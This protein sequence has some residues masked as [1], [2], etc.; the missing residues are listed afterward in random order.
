MITG[1]KENYGMLDSQTKEDDP[2]PFSIHDYLLYMCQD[3]VWADSICIQLLASMWRCRVTVLRSDSCKEI[4][5]RHDKDL[6]GADFFLVFNCDMEVGHYNAA[7]RVDKIYIAAAKLVRIR[8]FNFDK[9]ME[10][11]EERGEGVEIGKDHVVAER[12]KLR[13]L[14]YK[15]QK[16]DQIQQFIEDTSGVGLT[17]TDVS[18]VGKMPSKTSVQH[19][20]K[21]KEEELN[22]Q[23]VKEGDVKCEKCHRDF[24]STAD[25][26]Q[27]I[28]VKHNDLYSYVCS[29]CNK[30]FT[31]RP[32]YK[33][34]KLQHKSKV[35]IE[36][37][38]KE[39]LPAKGEKV[40][41]CLC[42]KMMHTKRKCTS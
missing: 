11:R 12:E 25:L 41:G 21:R 6:K 42:V 26:K 17:S 1:L 2:G 7:L 38:A 13:I 3:K 18:N 39:E 15:A 16:L 10:E 33:K 28:D 35:E 29:K 4:R 22:I 19:S 24:K 23:V 36:K 32:G 8:N 20:L 30:E 9:D 37:F 40:L 27:H 5:F 14:K 34:H 31:S